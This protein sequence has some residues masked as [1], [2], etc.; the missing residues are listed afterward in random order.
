MK[1][2]ASTR[3]FPAKSAGS[4]A[5]VSPCCRR[6][7]RRRVGDDRRPRPL[8]GRSEITMMLRKMRAA[9]R[10]PFVAGRDQHVVRE[11]DAAKHKADALRHQPPEAPPPPKPP[12]PAEKPPP[13]RPTAAAPRRANPARLTATPK[14]ASSHVL[15][16]RRRALAHHEIPVA[17]AGDNPHDDHEDDEQDNQKS[18]T[19]ADDALASAERLLRVR[20]EA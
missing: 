9:R 14:A 18:T 15:P 1:T 19:T 12:P 5:T 16:R 8:A 20:A 17:D 4:R 3:Y 2:A 11:H 13:R 10:T 7:L 6:T